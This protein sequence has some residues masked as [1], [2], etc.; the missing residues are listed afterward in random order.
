MTKQSKPRTTIWKVLFF[1]AG[2]SPILGIASLVIIALM[3]DLPN[4]ETLANPR[5]DLATK[6]YTMDGK[7]L[8]SYYNENRSDAKHEDLP[9]HLVEALISTEDVRYFSHDGID[10]YGL[11]RAI[12]FLG[13]RGGGSTITQQL[14]KLLFTEAYESTSFLERALLQKPKEWIIA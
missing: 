5:T 3:G 12:A 4:T 9:N 6:V 2:L 1:L 7:V 13:K 14:A 11:G 10:F 8:G